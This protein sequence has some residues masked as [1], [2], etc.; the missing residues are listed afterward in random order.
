M[1]WALSEV[2]AEVVNADAWRSGVEL[3]A[4]VRTEHDYWDRPL[5]RAYH[6]SMNC[7]QHGFAALAHAE[8]YHQ[9]DLHPGFPSVV[10][11]HSCAHVLASHRERLCYCKG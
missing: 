2:A 9:F 10:V 8:M 7:F 6:G 1:G 3:E 4:A 11:C 5:A